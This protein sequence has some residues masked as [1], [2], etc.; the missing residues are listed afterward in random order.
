M[1]QLPIPYGSVANDPNTANDIDL[2][3]AWQR[4]QDNFTDLYALQSRVVNAGDVRFASQPTI[5]ARI[6]A[7]IDQAV[8]ELASAVFV[9]AFMLPY[10]AS[11]VTFN[12]S[13]RMV[14]EGGSFDVFDVTAYGAPIDDSAD[15][16]PAFHA[17]LL[18]HN[19]FTD[20]ISFPG[21]T[22]HCDSSPF[23]GISLLQPCRIVGAGIE[24]T[25]IKKNFSGTWFP[26][27]INFGNHI[28]WEGIS[29]HGNAATFTGS[30]FAYSG[31]AGG[32]GNDYHSFFR[33]RFYDIPSP[34]FSVEGDGAGNITFVDCEAYP[35]PSQ[36][37]E[38]KVFAMT[39][40]DT[41]ARFRRILNCIFNAGYIGIDGAND[42]FVSNCALKRIETSATTAEYFIGTTLWGNLSAAMTIKGQ[43][44][45]TG[46]RF[47][48]N[49]TIDVSFAG[50]FVGNFQTAGTFTD[51]TTSAGAATVLH[52]PLSVNYA[53]LDHLRFSGTKNPEEIQT[54]RVSA[55]QGD[56]NSTL[57]LDQDATCVYFNTPLTGN[58]TFT[59]PS[60]TG[61]RDGKTIRVVR[62][63]L[64]TGGSTLTSVGSTPEV[65]LA[66]GTWSDFTRNGPLSQWTPTAGGTLP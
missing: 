26:I 36:G 32:S 49:V 48:G 17:A 46:C 39:S 31:Q 15:L 47:S 20:P 8:V 37:T 63:K 65:V 56:A 14:R 4:T 41:G 45:I 19:V 66:V 2:R 29:F 11:L 59:L 6:Q 60:V 25:I 64:A 34:H 53:V 1:A 21:G 9:P 16:T 12:T 10:D 33:C 18:A 35:G 52:H 24:S 54:F 50:M 13:I 7:A 57:T 43:G 27:G 30:A 51:N 23:T 42:T 44:T 28:G 3:T 62:S 55:D 38:Y 61:N 5:E 22:Y 40:D 58:R